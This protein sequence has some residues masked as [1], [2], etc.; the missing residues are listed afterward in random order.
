M[1][2]SLYADG[3]VI[4]KNPST[5]GGTWAFRILNECGTPICERSGAITPAECYLPAVTNNLTEMLAVVSGLRI[6]PSNWR[7][8]IYSDSQ[9]TLGRLFGSWKWTGIPPWLHKQFAAEARRLVYWTQ[10]KY[11][12]LQGHPTAAELE[13]GVGHTGR[14]VSEHNQWCDRE[15]GRIAKQYK[16]RAHEIRR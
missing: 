4:G 8:V 16:E 10:I 2:G 1:S 11:I 9:I 14:P 3:G 7:G 6:F 12:L 13:A 15:C 5:I